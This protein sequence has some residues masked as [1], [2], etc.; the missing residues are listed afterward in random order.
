MTMSERKFRLLLTDFIRQ[1]DA[2]FTAGSNA[3]LLYVA[4]GNFI[5]DH[6]GRRDYNREMLYR[7][8]RGA[9]KHLGENKRM[10]MPNPAQMRAVA[11]AYREIDSPL[12]SE[13][14]QWLS[15]EH[16]VQLVAKVKEAPA[17]LFYLTVALREDLTGEDL[18]RWIDCGIYERFVRRQ[19]SQMPQGGASV[20][21]KYPAR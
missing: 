11:A 20:S 13:G 4:I 2:V 12:L 19:L 9:K 14:L 15:W 7:L 16:H 3:G 8:F 21:P 5:L 18:V 6:E 17:L 10:T 1:I